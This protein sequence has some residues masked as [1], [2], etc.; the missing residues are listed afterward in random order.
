MGGRKGKGKGRSGN[1]MP[2]RMS[3]CEKKQANPGCVF[4]VTIVNRN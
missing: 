2:L 4:T 3:P 1:T